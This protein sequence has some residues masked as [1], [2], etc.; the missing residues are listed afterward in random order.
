[1]KRYSFST[2]LS[3]GTSDLNQSQEFQI[4]VLAG[5][6]AYNS[7]YTYLDGNIRCFI[8]PKN[9][10]PNDKKYRGKF[11]RYRFFRITSS[12]L[13]PEGHHFV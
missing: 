3:N 5:L 7:T 9:H 12:L 2:I 8:N 10:D 13:H 4:S 6:P 1:M 11:V